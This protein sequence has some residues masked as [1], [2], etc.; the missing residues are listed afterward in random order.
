[1]LTSRFSDFNN[2]VGKTDAD[3]FNKV[4]S[5]VPGRR[6]TY[7]SLTGKEGARPF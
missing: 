7:E 1:M 4:L 3:R 2:R 5:Q 6:L